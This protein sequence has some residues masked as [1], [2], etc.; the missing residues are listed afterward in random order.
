MR[1]GG[2][3]YGMSV[4]K[5]DPRAE[6]LA[7][8]TSFGD[9]RR[10]AG[11]KPLRIS[12]G[13][14]AEGFGYTRP[15]NESIFKTVLPH[16]LADFG[17]L[18]GYPQAPYTNTYFVSEMKSV[19]GVELAKALMDD[20]VLVQAWDYFKEKSKELSEFTDTDVKKTKTPFYRAKPATQA[21]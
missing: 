10:L 11:Q 21:A 5:R 13:T 18:A 2:L 6:I 19:F 15:Y 1:L 8:K 9:P 16:K 14:W 12:G 20:K 4:N 7:T 3:A 17:T